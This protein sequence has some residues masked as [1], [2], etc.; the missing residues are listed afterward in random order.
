[1]NAA[2]LAAGDLFHLA[3]A[4][5][6][7]TYQESGLIS[8]PSLD[9]EGFVHC[10]WGR[11]VAGTVGRHFAGRTDLLA[12]RL[13]SDDVGSPLVEED[14]YASG[15]SYPHVYGPIPVAAVLD[16]TPLDVSRPDAPRS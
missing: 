6:W 10:S 3:S 16:A 1:V 7:A 11:Q 15:Q 14:S 2:D 4:G 12:L 13:A 5:E 9:D 8:P